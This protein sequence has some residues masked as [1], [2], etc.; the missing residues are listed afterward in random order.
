MIYDLPL[1]MNL[2]IMSPTSTPV[3]FHCGLS[4]LRVMDGWAGIFPLWTTLLI[5]PC[6]FRFKLKNHYFTFSMK[7]DATEPPSR[8]SLWEISHVL[9][10]IRKK[11]F[12]PRI[13]ES[14]IKQVLEETPQITDFKNWKRPSSSSGPIFFTDVVKFIPLELPPLST[15]CSGLATHKVKS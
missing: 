12:F 7:K 13:W 4:Q 8:S 1:L 6:G 14:K 5:R 9:P 15:D 3:S 10:F 2:G 11:Y